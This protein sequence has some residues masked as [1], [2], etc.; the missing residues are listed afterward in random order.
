MLD[1]RH[2]RNMTDD[3]GMLQFS[4]LAQ[5]DPK[6]GYTLDDNARAL[7]VA[8]FTSQGADLAFKYARF[9]YGAQ[10]PDGSWSNL[11]NNG[12]YY[13]HCNSE[14]SIGRALAACSASMWC[15]HPGVAT[16]CEQMFN[17]NL[18]RS[19]HF[20]SPRAMAYTIIALCKCR[21]PERRDQFLRTR[22][23]D[24]LISL[25]KECCGAGWYWFENYLTYCNGIIPQALFAAYG[26]SSDKR[27]YKVAQESLNFLN[28]ILFRNGHLD[29]IGNAGWYHRDG[30]IPLYDQQPV[31]AA[32]IIFACHEAFQTVGIREYYNLAKLASQ[33]YQGKNAQQAALLDN[34]SGGCYDALTAT[35]V[36]KNQGAE[37]VLSLLLSTMLMQGQL[38]QKDD[39]D[40]TLANLS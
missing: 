2:L 10:R 18:P 12:R 37:A 40:I 8:A 36:N 20:R 17:S 1:D 23:V 14:D 7:M 19:A 29:I 11:L 26:L 38:E 27:I 6:S 5:P 34:E 22:L 28:G 4:K 31:D 33:W 13:S 16:L 3:I 21:H 9:M 32:S 39:D 24:N 35:G 30:Q 25:Y 15:S